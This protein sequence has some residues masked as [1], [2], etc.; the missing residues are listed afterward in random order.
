[1][2]PSRYRLLKVLPLLQTAKAEESFVC[3]GYQLLPAPLSI[4]GDWSSCDCFL[5][6]SL[7]GMNSN[8]TTGLMYM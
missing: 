2:L 7:I 6:Q 5:Y 8:S 4:V 1:M 3:K